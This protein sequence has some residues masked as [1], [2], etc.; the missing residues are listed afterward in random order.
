MSTSTPLLS[1]KF[2]Q[3]G[4]SAS[5]NKAFQQYLPSCEPVYPMTPSWVDQAFPVWSSIGIGCHWSSLHG[6]FLLGECGIPLETRRQS[7]SA[8]WCSHQN[9]E[10]CS[11]TS[12]WLS[13]SCHVPLEKGR[14]MRRFFSIPLGN[15]L[16][17]FLALLPISKA[18]GAKVSWY[19][20]IRLIMM[21]ISLPSVRGSIISFRWPTLRTDFI[22]FQR[23]HNIYCTVQLC[24]SACA[25]ADSGVG[26]SHLT[27]HCQ[28]VC[29]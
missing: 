25:T 13:V 17:L 4:S 14:Q 20:T 21:I 10:Q 28:N 9:S 12:R 23:P 24:I 2:T 7:C 22:P 3:N 27:G 11:C 26:R 18:R 15:A 1:A 29:P 19:A 8:A 16:L 5:E 6:W